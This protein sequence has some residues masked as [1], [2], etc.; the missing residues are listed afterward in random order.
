MKK[1]P[2]GFCD[3]CGFRYDLNELR[4]EL[5]PQGRPTYRVCS[6]CFD[7]IHPQDVPFVFV[8]E[9]ESLDDPRPDLSLEKS[10]EIPGGAIPVEDL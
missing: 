3:R 10:R 6:T 1:Q 4:Y 9:R 7:P 2:H 5:S 8:P